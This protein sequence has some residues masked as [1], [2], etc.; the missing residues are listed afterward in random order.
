MPQAH[1]GRDAIGE[2]LRRAVHLVRHGVHLHLT[3]MDEA[4]GAEAATALRQR[5]DEQISSGHPEA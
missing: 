3:P 4:A 1:P 5:Y 2:Y